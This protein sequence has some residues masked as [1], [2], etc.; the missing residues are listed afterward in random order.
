MTEQNEKTLLADIEGLRH[1]FPQT[2]DLYRE[3]CAVMFFRYGMTPTANKLYQLVRKGSMSA[4]AEALH[5][6][7][8]N[9]REK[10]RVTVNH[11]D[12]PDSL[13]DAAGD[14]VATLWKT[15]QAAAHETLASFQI[16]AQ[17]QVD[18]AMEAK[19][20]AFDVRDQA[21]IS[22]ASIQDEMARSRLEFDALR[23]EI[24]ALTSTKSMVESQ[25]LDARTE[26]TA[27]QARL[28]DARRDFA[29]EMEKLR[30]AAQKSEERLGAAETRALLEID[31]ERTAAIRL[32][33][34]LET[35]RAEG[36]TDADRHRA[37]CN[38]LQTQVA[39]LRHA[40]GV[41]EGT[42]NTISE[43]RNAAARELETSRIQLSD[44]SAEIAALRA[45]R[46]TLLRKLQKYESATRKR[47]TAAQQQTQAKRRKKQE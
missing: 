46:A 19:K 20:Q 26:L 24:T 28:D 22:L 29:S 5:R 35:A 1:Q 37:E 31:R 40:N 47:D 3:V 32:Q 10:S 15:A 42:I 2:Q 27:N 30:I 4:P 12:L 45:E 6:F 25:L 44:T 33:K 17:A 39:E 7:W 41:L 38:V 9:L 16:A 8:E 36:K 14:L 21:R 43:S 23:H 11:P 13:K 34:L 18:E